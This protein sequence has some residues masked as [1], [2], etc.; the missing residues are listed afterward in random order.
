MTETKTDDEEMT[1]IKIKLNILSLSKTA[2][3]VEDRV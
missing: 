3:A 2:V 1:V